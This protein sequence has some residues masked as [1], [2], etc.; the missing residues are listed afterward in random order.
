[1]RPKGDVVDRGEAVGTTEPTIDRQD[2][3]NPGKRKSRQ[4][5]A[6]ESMVGG[7][8]PTEAIHTNNSELTMASSMSDIQNNKAKVSLF[9]LL[10]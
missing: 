8:A 7:N 5:C 4:G 10:N 1:M 3:R 2:M 9:F 6:K